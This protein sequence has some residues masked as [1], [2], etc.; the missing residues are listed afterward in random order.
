MGS[1]FP[2]VL[3]QT[4]RVAVYLGTTLA[5]VLNTTPLASTI[6]N[7][8]GFSIWSVGGGTRRMRDVAAVVKGHSLTGS[9]RFGGAGERTRNL[10]I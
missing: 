2:T 6:A 5:F 8:N 10:G 7:R 4:G 1:M 3:D 9:E